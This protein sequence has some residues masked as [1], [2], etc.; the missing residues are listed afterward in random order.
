[1]DKSHQ[2]SYCC[3]VHVRFDDIRKANHDGHSHSENSKRVDQKMAEKL[4]DRIRFTILC[5][6]A[7]Y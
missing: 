1:M 5:R 2:H 3:S 4:Y 6:W 7:A